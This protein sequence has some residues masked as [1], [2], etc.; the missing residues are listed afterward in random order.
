VEELTRLRRFRESDAVEWFAAMDY[1]YTHLTAVLLG[2]RDHQDNIY[3]LDEHASRFGIPQE[4]A[5]AIKAMLARHHVYADR[6]HLR[7]V[8]LAEFPDGACTQRNQ[9]WHRRQK[10]LLAGFFAGSD[11]FSAESNGQSVAQQYKELGLGLRPASMDRVGGWSVLLKRLGNPAA[12]V[13]PTL[14][15]H[16]RCAQLLACLPRV[17]HDPDRPGDVL[18]TNVSDDGTGGDDLADCLRYLV[19]TKLPWFRV[20]KL[21]GL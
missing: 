15:I 5:Q 12:G 7:E 17:Q 14:F 11:A 10:R 9:L 13:L 16:Q 2:C 4:H 21:R 20:V 18:K 1:G 6:E 3:V 8:L 19:A